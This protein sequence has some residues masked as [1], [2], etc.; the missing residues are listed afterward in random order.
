MVNLDGRVVGVNKAIVS[1]MGGGS[2][3]VSF[4]TPINLV[5]EILPQ[6][7]ANGKVTRGWV[8]MAI[9]PVTPEIARSL[10]FDKPRGAIVADV[11]QGGPAEQGGIKAGD[12]VTEYDGQA[13]NEAG[14]LPL[15][16]ARTPVGKKVEVKVLRENKELPLTVTINELLEP[17]GSG[18]VRT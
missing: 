1:Q 2:I 7:R 5:K 3:G 18:L 10:G 17:S 16:V 14:E 4:A 13:I 9:H 8:G 11:A 6:L 12:I 15:M